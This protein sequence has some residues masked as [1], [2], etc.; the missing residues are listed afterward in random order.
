MELK[1]KVEWM[2]VRPNG[3]VVDRWEGPNTILDKMKQEMAYALGHTTFTAV[4]A[5]DFKRQD[6]GWGN[7]QPTTIDG[8]GTGSENWIRWR[9]DYTASETVTITEVKLG[10]AA[11]ATLLTSEYAEYNIADVA[12]NSG[13]TLIVKWTVTVS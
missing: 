8:G 6:T 2:H 4:D 12:L 5:I 11:G 1:G 9:A 13:D 10:V 3:E 7:S